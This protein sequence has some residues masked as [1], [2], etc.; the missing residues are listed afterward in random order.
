M[1]NVDGEEPFT[2][3][4]RRLAVEEAR[5]CRWSVYVVRV[6][7]TRHHQAPAIK[8]GMVGTGTIGERLAVHTAT[9]GQTELL[10]AWT[11]PHALG[12]LPYPQ[13]WRLVEQYEAGLQFAPEFAYPD[14][15]LRRLRA[16][17]L[18]YSFE[19]F[20]DDERVV[21]AVAWQAPLPV[22]LPHGWTLACASHPPER[23]DET[24]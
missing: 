2:V 1:S 17:T 23:F 19:W 6:D 7:L 9:Y 10:D 16:D 11:L 14:A 22:T 12:E 3:F 20:E 4:P 13:P 8:I 15:R 5:P 18:V 24:P 21:D